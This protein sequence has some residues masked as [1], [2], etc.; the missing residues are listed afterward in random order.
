MQSGPVQR[1]FAAYS[2]TAKAEAGPKGAR[3]CSHAGPGGKR[4]VGAGPSPDEMPSPRHNAKLATSIDESVQIRA[5]ENR[6]A[7]ISYDCGSEIGVAIS[8][9][10]VQLYAPGARK[11]FLGKLSETAVSDFFC[12]LFR[13][14]LA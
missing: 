2:V 3:T 10:T 12:I 4:S 11:Q 7:A 13:V 14:P 6:H 1:D 5:E 9:T 8:Q